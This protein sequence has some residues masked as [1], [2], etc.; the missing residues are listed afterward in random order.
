MTEIGLRLIDSILIQ[1]Y[2]NLGSLKISF[3]MFSV[4]YIE[5]SLIF[6]ILNAE[7]KFDSVAGL[8][9]L[10]N[11]WHAAYHTPIGLNI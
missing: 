7:L 3:S 6:Q 9:V 11:T 1:I 5:I 4:E 10:K 8:S 2:T